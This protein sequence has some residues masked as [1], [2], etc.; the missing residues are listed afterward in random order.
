[1]IRGW[2]VTKTSQHR[3]GEISDVCITISEAYISGSR[4]KRVASLII[5]NHP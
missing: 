2:H 5:L 1:M 3:T 4:N